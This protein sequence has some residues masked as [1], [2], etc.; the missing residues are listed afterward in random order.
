MDNRLNIGVKNTFDFPKL[1][2]K[3]FSEN[4]LKPLLVFSNGMSNM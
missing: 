3:Q 2:N 4:V 1:E